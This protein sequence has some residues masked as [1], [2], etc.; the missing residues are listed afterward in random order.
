MWKGQNQYI[1]KNDPYGG[2]GGSIGR[3]SASRSN[4]VHEVRIPSGAQE[5]FVRDFP[6]QKCR[7]DSLSVCP[8]PVCIH[9]NV[10]TL[11]IMQSMSD[12]DGLG[13][14]ENNQHVL[15]PPKIDR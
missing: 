15:V 5:Q 3:A 11:K 14:H 2:R 9:K 6:S 10:R 7:A 8:T 4:G 13:K 1:D 12:F